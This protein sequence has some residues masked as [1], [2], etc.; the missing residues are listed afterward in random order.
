MIEKIEAPIRWE[1]VSP[2]LLVTIL[3]IYIYFYMLLS[4]DSPNYYSNL[5]NSLKI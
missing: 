2:F 3:N 5:F 4:V 1:E